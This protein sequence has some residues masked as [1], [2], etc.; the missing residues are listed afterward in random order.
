MNACTSSGARPRN[1]AEQ[2][3][4]LLPLLVGAGAFLAL[5]LA[6]AA[7]LSKPPVPPSVRA[8]CVV[9]PVTALVAWIVLE[10]RFLLRCDERQRRIQLEAFAIAYPLA[11]AL[12]LALF[13][14]RQAGLFAVEVRWT[15]LP[16]PYFVAL[17]L[18]KLRG[19]GA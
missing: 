12:V 9:L 5:Y 19:A 8:A 3:R 16:L 7:I 18:A 6:A 13:L 2:R 1:G 11:I 14:L 17:G 4:E 15:Y 10:V